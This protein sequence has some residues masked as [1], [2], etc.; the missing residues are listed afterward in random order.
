MQLQDTDIAPILKWQEA[1]SRPF[2]AKVC[3]SSPATRHYWNLWDSLEVR[4]GVL[5]RRFIKR[6]CSGTYLQFL[7]PAKLRSEILHQMHHAIFSG[8]LGKK[9]TR[10]KTLQHF[11]WYGLREDTN[12]WVQ[13]CD[14]CGAVKTPPK[15]LRAP[16]G[17]M[18]VGAPMDRLGT[19]FLGPLP[20]TPR[21][22]R[23][24]L[25][26]TDYFT[27]WVEIFAL[28]DQTA[29]TTA[30]VILNEVIA[31]YGCPFEIHSDQGR[32]YES[33]IF[34]ELCRML[35]IRKT[36]TSP[37]NPQCNGQTERFNKTL[38]RMI[39][40]YLKGQQRDWDRNLGRCLSF[41]AT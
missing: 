32:N 20:L 35:E 37:G 29:I 11:Y 33:T 31:R 6:D 3:E 30:E 26:V 13:G 28:P 40:A 41:L 10:E 18:P 5:F 23:Y 12:N 36:R 15:S 9:K 21:G 39:K 27:K 19:D 17:A 34:T 7:V 8:H 38:I 14:I 22:N 25:V 2:G 4:D 1:G 16:L 24:I